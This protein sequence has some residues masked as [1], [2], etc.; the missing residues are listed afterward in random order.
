MLKF[1][2]GKFFVALRL[3]FTNGL[4][5]VPRGWL[6]SVILRN[7]D[8]NLFDR[9]S[10]DR[11]S[12]STPILFPSLASASSFLS[13]ST[14]SPKRLFHLAP[15]SQKLLS[16]FPHLAHVFPNSV[17]T[18][19]NS[20]DSTK[21]SSKCSSKFSSSNVV[22]LDSFLSSA[23]F[24]SSVS[25][26]SVLRLMPNLSSFLSSSGSHS[27]LSGRS[28]SHSLIS[29]SLSIAHKDFFALS[30]DV[31]FASLLASYVSKSSSSTSSTK[32]K[33]QNLQ[34]QVKKDHSS[35]QNDQSLQ[36]QTKKDQ[37]KKNHA[38]AQMDQTKKDQTTHSFYSSSL[39][40]PPRSTKRDRFSYD[41]DSDSFLSSCSF[42]P[43]NPS[44]PLH[45]QVTLVIFLVKLFFKK[46]T[47]A[48]LPLFFVFS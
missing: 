23:T 2:L 27:D 20:K 45:R 17:S 14:S 13:P 5:K 30:P 10:S 7:L 4:K 22:S 40:M 3:L 29:S 8:S 33:D 25:V 24:D 37:T 48:L 18:F 15:L 34:L 31:P 12:D 35:A 43:I 32:K 11:L 9:S 42:F 26:D 16:D 21:R 19:P 6:P 1:F 39:L 38:S 28:W 47:G 46:V 36:L 44:L 41:L